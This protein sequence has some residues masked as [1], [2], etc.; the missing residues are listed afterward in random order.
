MA[1][2]VAGVRYSICIGFFTTL[3]KTKFYPQV[4]DDLYPHF[5]EDFTLSFTIKNTLSNHEKTP[6]EIF[7]K[8]TLS[9]AVN[10]PSEKF[11]IF[12]LSF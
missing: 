1:T 7:K 8:S 5:A 10:L 11:G 6:S 4:A 3:N 12:T 2:S 9:E